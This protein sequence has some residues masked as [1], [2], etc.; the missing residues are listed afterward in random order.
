MIFNVLY[1]FD[2][3]INLLSIEK[4]LNID[5]EIVFYKKKLC[6]NLKQYNINR[7]AKL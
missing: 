2:M 4:F 1:M 3:N 5:I 6:F 7:Y